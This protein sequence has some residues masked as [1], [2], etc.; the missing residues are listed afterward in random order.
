MEELLPYTNTPKP[1]IYNCVCC[2]HRSTNSCSHSHNGGEH[3]SLNHLCNHLK[4][5]VAQIIHYI[6]SAYQSFSR[7]DIWDISLT[8][9]GENKGSISLPRQWWQVIYILGFSCNKNNI[10]HL[11]RRNKIIWSHKRRMLLTRT[12]SNSLQLRH[13]FSQ[14]PQV[15]VSFKYLLPW[16]QWSNQIISST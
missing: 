9:T 6:K 14:R 13:W 7:I 12:L 11:K 4:S 5:G 15:L 1:A 10:L 8:Y 3:C 2:S 16:R